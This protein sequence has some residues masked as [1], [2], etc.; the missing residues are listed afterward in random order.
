MRLLKHQDAALIIV[1]QLAAAGTSG[2]ISLSDISRKHGVS[3]YYLK[4]IARLL[5]S[6]GLIQSREGRSGGYELS[7]APSIITVWDVIVAV[8]QAEKLKE[9]NQSQAGDCPLH[10]R[11]LPQIIRR[12]V[13]QELKKSLTKINISSIS[14]EIT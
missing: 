11:C 9:Y 7:K 4:K 6:A 5:R 10:H 13:V 12:R 8:D 3:V 1:I 14:G 2:L